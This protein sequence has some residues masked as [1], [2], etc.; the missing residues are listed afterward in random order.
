MVIDIPLNYKAEDTP[1][2]LDVLASKARHKVLVCH[3]RARKT[4]L[5]VTHAIRRKFS[6]PRNVL[7][8]APYSDQ[9]RKMIWEA[10]NMMQRFLPPEIW[11]NRHDTS[12]KLKTPNGG[13]LYC[14]GADNFDSFRGL[15]IGTIILDEFDDM[16]PKLWSEVLSPIIEVGG[17]EVWFAG[18]LKGR[19]NLWDKLQ[20]A[21]NSGDPDWQGV[22]LS[23]ETSG[24]IPPAVL[25][26]IKKT[27]PKA[28]YEQEYL[29]KPITSGSQVFRDPRSLVKAVAFDR[30]HRHRI[31]IDLAKRSDF[32]VITNVDVSLPQF[33]VLQQERFNKIDWS[34][35]R[36]MIEASWHRHNSPHGFVDATGVGDPMAET[37]EKTCPGLLGYRFTGPSRESLIS[38][39]VMVMEEKRITLPDDDGLISEL[40]S[41]RWV[42]SKEDASP[43][44][45]RVKYRAEAPSSMHDDRVM[46]LALACWELPTRQEFYYGD[47]NRVQ[48]NR[49][50]TRSEY[51]QQ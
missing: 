6:D 19:S 17:G 21:L 34:I 9:C 23:A 32:T 28:V 25:E 13:F 22:L 48:R 42:A 29:C 3:R 12:M 35:Q 38:N 8:L 14:G 51:A 20:Y 15:E 36:G 18:T 46:S 27:T 33:A 5:C 7:Y 16:D 44:D 4:T 49:G 30:Q 26:Q 47:D 39:L 1:W 43:T 11:D 2:H 40:E 50:A 37:L 10:P 31:G 24:V 41:F 45:S